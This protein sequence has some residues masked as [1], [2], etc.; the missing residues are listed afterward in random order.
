L[1]DSGRARLDGAEA[2]LLGVTGKGGK[3][4]T[5][6]VFDEIKT[7]HSDLWVTS[8]QRRMPRTSFAA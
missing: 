4:R 2:W 8:A 1:K 6:M 7:H 5:V 3:L